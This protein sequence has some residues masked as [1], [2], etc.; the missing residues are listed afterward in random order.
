MTK[1]ELIG[2]A[3]GWVIGNFLWNAAALLFKAK[4]DWNF[5]WKGSLQVLAFV[6]INLFLRGKL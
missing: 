2:A 5:A 3:V 6:F 1:A 4:P